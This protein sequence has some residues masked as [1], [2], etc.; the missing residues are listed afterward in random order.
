MSKLS[1]YQIFVAIVEAGSIIQAALKL[2]YSA[3]AVSKQLTKLE[4]DL[5]V[6]LFHRSHKKLEITEAGERFYPRCK[7][8]LASISQAEDELLA[9]N[10]A[11]SG[12]ISITLSKALA[13]STIFDAL[14]SFTHK[15]PQIQFDIRFSDNLE[16]LHNENLDFAFRLGKLQDNSHM[17]AIPLLEAQ[18]VACA[19]Q[20]YLERH[21]IPK[22]FSDL[23]SSKLI[24]MSPLH[25]SE[26][27][28]RF[29]NKEKL[30]PDNI[31]AHSC[32]DIEG[33]YQSVRSGLGIGMMLNISVEQELREG[34][35]T[36]ILA[37]RN[38][39]KKRLYLLYKKSHWKTQKQIAFK[40]HIKS[41]L[42]A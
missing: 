23:G 26:A 19:T 32:N 14:A 16:D 13:R 10:E 27:L 9:E 5:K 8:I 7:N 42:S 35:F 25:S 39:P 20:S 22:Q 15:Y 38:L 18:L 1:N 36:S 31:M 37:E 30:R 3:P 41:F 17:V 6:Q 11:I 2:N 24:L 12:T 29:F 34:T 28:R 40:E 21:G 33:I 4:Q